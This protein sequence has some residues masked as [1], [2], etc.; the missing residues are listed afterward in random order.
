DA[1]RL[2]AVRG[3]LMQA[4]PVGGAMVAV[5]ATEDEVAARLADRTDQVGIAAVNGPASVVISGDKYAVL[6]LAGMW[7]AEGRRVKRLRVSHAFHSPLMEPMLDEFRAE[8][9]R[10]SSRG[11]A[12]DAGRDTGDLPLFVS[13]VAPGDTDVRDVARAEYWVR[14]AREA[15]RFA[16]CVRHLEDLGTGMLLELGPDTV[17]APMAEACL[18][19]ERTLTLASAMRR[20]RDEVRTLTDALAAAHLSGTDVDWEAY[21]AAL[22]ARHERPVPRTAALPTYPFQRLRF[23]TET[24]RAPRTAVPAGV[25][26]TGHPLLGAAVELPEAGGLVMTGRLSLAEQ[27][28][29]AD[30]RVAGAVLFPGTGFVELVARA[31]EWL[32]CGVVEELTLQAPLVLPE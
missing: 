12:V 11:P 10:L 13:A 7:Q 9:R 18:S 24:G 6:E 20:N 29:L 19:G 26:T 31:G 16:D 17:L 27:P 15:V 22:S 14:H 1:A 32:G 2:V 21:A 3:R 30:H 25:R 8:L 5:Q 28:W 4:L 23:W